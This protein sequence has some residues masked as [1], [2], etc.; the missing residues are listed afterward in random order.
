MAQHLLVRLRGWV[1]HGLAP[2]L[3]ARPTG[4]GYNIPPGPAVSDHSPVEMTIAYVRTRFATPLVHG[5]RLL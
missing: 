1:Y 2:R 4:K 5:G 3:T